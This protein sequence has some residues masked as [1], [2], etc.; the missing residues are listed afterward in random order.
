MKAKHLLAIALCSFLLSACLSADVES[1]IN[2][3]ENSAPIELDALEQV[4][5]SE[6]ASTIQDAMNSQNEEMCEALNDKALLDICKSKVS[7][8]ILLNEAFENAD[9]ENCEKIS[10]ESTKQKCEIQAQQAIDEVEKNK[11]FEDEQALLH[12]LDNG[13][14]F[15]ACD[16]LTDINFIEECRVDVIINRAM[17]DNDKDFCESLEGKYQEFCFQMLPQE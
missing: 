16:Q 17:Q 13:K 10:D 14:D 4:D 6:D 5:A 2:A 7:D 11:A 1:E 3:S 9:L 12:E 15:E 8:E